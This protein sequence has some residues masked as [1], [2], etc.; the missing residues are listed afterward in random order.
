MQQLAHNAEPPNANAHRI[1]QIP[2]RHVLLAKVVRLNARGPGKGRDLAIYPPE[3][4]PKLRRV[5]LSAPRICQLNLHQTKT[6]ETIFVCIF[7]TSMTGR[8]VSFMSSHCGTLFV[9]ALYQ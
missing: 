2:S 8:T 7:V 9:T 6:Y 5:H 1:L 4:Y 3:C